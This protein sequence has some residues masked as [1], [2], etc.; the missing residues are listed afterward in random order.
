M[1]SS[2]TDDAS[3]NGREDDITLSAA[4][5]NRSHVSECERIVE[6]ALKDY[7]TELR[8]DMEAR[9]SQYAHIELSWSGRYQRGLVVGLIS[10]IKK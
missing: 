1:L 4:W 10:H 8:K 7:V 6:D 5:I 3:V 9:T 2:A